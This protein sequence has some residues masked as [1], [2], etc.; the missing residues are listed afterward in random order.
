MLRHEESHHDWNTQHGGGV[1]WNEEPPRRLQAL[2]AAELAMSDKLSSR[3]SATALACRPEVCLWLVAGISGSLLFWLVQ[4]VAGSGTIT[5]FFGQQIV[6]AGGYPAWLG[7]L[8]GWA[9]HLGVSLAYAAVL[10]V[11]VVMVRRAEV[12]F[13]ATLAFVAALVL[14]W[15]TAFVAPPAISVTIALL[16]GQG[17][18][19]TL[20]PF[21]TEPG[22]PLWNH[23]LFFI[24]SWAIQGLGPRWVGQPSPRR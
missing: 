11:F 7:P 14:G 3:G 19:T 23:L 17:F 16:G 22:L 10:G 1:D 20:F 21:N 24:V 4:V 12:R 18:P 15:V 5:E 6:A 2:G 13:A 9:V 8:I